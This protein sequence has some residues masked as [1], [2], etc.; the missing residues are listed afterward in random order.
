MSDLIELL[1]DIASLESTRLDM[2]QHVM[3][4]LFN[5]KEQL[6][7]LYTNSTMSANLAAASGHHNEYSTVS[8]SKFIPLMLGTTN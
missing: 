6:D 1:S 8:I 4:L 2:D 7:N 5:I 3:S